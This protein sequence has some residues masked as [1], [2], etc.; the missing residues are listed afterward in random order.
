MQSAKISKQQQQ[1]TIAVKPKITTLK[2]E[3]LYTVND[4][5]PYTPYKPD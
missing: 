4:I 1:K 2:L 5:K 3:T